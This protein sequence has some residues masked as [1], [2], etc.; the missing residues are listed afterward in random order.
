MYLR[1]AENEGDSETA[2]YL[3]ELIVEEKKRA[4]RAKTLLA[5]RL[6]KQ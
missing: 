6:T 1:D 2:R 3:K 5:Q 4:E